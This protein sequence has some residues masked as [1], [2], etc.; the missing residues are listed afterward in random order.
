[1]GLWNEAEA[2][3]LDWASV[4]DHFMPIESDPAGSCFEGPTLLSALAAGTSRITCGLLVAGNTYRHPAVLANIAVT[5]DHISNGRLELGVGAGWY[6]LEH[7]QYGI[8]FG[9]FGERARRLAESA[10]I[11]QRLWTEETVTHAGS[12]YSLRE[13]RCEPKP[14]RGN[15]PLWI[16][17]AGEVVMLGIVARLAHGWN[18]FLLPADEYQVKTSALEQHC[19]AIG[20]DPATIRRSLIFQAVI[21]ETEADL[22]DGVAWL[23]RAKGI[24]PELVRSSALIGTPH[25]V[26]SRLANYRALGVADFLLAARPPVDYETLRLVGTQVAPELRRGI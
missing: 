15:I 6:E 13:A 25:E 14:S 10:T 9:P 18:T 24:P 12:F 20:R 16:G 5:I 4:F 3:G 21:R 19:K 7:D 1:V 8:T 26:A 17:A 2:L 11:I 23:A 22:A